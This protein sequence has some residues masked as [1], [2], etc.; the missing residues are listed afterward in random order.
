MFN[1]SL[2]SGGEKIPKAV[3]VHTKIIE[4]PKTRYFE[5]PTYSYGSRGGMLEFYLMINFFIMSKLNCWLLGFFFF[6][7]INIHSK[8]ALVP[9][10]LT[11]LKFN[12]VTSTRY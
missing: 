2:L 10:K 9:T 12:F 8:P 7:L 5:I 3:I 6:F 4:I 1:L 11:T